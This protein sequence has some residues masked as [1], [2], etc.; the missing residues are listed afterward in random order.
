MLLEIKVCAI[1]CFRGHTNPRTLLTRPQPVLSTVAR[2]GPPVDEKDPL[3]L[4]DFET[5][6]LVRACGLDCSD[7]LAQLMSGIV[8]LKNV[9]LP[10]RPA[11]TGIIYADKASKGAA[12]YRGKTV[13]G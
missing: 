9:V 5:A 2:P 3:L 7:V 11:K 1:N 6:L 4:S 12:H 10:H 8:R 13:W